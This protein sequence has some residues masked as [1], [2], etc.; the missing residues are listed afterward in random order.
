MDELLPTKSRVDRHYLDD[1]RHIQ[2]FFYYA[3]R[4]ARIDRHSGFPSQFPD[5][6]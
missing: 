2:R 6:L 5:S 4:G 1:I 3:E